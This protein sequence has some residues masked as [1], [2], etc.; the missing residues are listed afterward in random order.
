[1]KFSVE[2]VLIQFLCFQFGA[3]QWVIQN[4]TGKFYALQHLVELVELCEFTWPF[5]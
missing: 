1:M 5:A 2:F 3:V 4:K